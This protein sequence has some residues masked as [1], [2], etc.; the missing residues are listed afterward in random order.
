MIQEGL[1]VLPRVQKKGGAGKRVSPEAIAV[2]KS[3]AREKHEAIAVVCITPFYVKPPVAGN[4]CI[5][6]DTVADR[7]WQ[8]H[9]PIVPD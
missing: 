2:L 5:I 1:C 3:E 9:I 6:A 8:Q 7:V 4:G